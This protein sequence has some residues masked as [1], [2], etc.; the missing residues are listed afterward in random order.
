MSRKESSLCD[1]KSSILLKVLTTRSC[2]VPAPVACCTYSS[3]FSC[4]CHAV[5]ALRD[6]ISDVIHTGVVITVVDT[7]S[8]NT[9]SMEQFWNF[10][11]RST[12]PTA[13]E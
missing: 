8:R 2:F 11:S 6:D 5:S 13:E 1:G 12:V 7:S 10:A 3:K 4:S 9:D